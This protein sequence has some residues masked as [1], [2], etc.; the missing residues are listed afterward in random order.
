MHYSV[1]FLVDVFA[2]KVRER[3]RGGR[4][5]EEIGED[6]EREQLWERGRGERER[7]RKDRK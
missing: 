2:K 4:E 3:E 7:G 1:S 6:R 5:G